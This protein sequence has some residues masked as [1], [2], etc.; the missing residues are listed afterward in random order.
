MLG[1]REES[2]QRD[3][4]GE[5]SMDYHESPLRLWPSPVMNSFNRAIPEGIRKSLAESYVCLKAKAYTASVVMSGRALEAIGR[6]FW[7][8]EEGDNPLMLGKGL[9]KLKDEGKID[10]RLF[11]WGKELAD[12]RN[13]AAHPSG[14]KFSKQ[15]AQDAFKFTYNICEYIFVLTEDFEQFKQRKAEQGRPPK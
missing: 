11:E 6:H 3:E 2:V 8:S 1:C 12:Y 5:L 7:P 13:W 9:K 10:E 15:D 14:A 4:T